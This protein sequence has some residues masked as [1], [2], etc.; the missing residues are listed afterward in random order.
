[1]KVDVKYT[2]EQIENACKKCVNA[3]DLET[4]IVYACEEMFH[5]YTEVAEEDSLDTFMK[6]F[7]Q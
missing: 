5:H 4:L 7:R 6:E 1:M 2:D 3:W